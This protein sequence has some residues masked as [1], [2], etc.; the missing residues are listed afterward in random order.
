MKEGPIKYSR[1]SKVISGR[2]HDELVMMDLDSGKYFSLNG[3]ATRIW[4]L[5][6]KPLDIDSLCGILAGEYD[7]DEANCHSAVEEYLKEMI[8][9]ELVSRRT[10]EPAG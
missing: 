7:V 3:V 1:N 4:D 6:E 2:L 9:L 8:R 10:G 5:L